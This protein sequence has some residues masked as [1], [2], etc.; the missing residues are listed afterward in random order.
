MYLCGDVEAMLGARDGDVRVFF[1]DADARLSP[2]P[3]GFAGMIGERKV[4]FSPSSNGGTASLKVEG[5]PVYPA[6]ER[7]P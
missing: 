6:C 3:D 2:S 1:P 4:S 7:L 5:G